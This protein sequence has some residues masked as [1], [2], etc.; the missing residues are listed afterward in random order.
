MKSIYV[1]ELKATLSKAEIYKVLVMDIIAGAK[2]VDWRDFFPYLRWIPNKQ[3]KKKIRAVSLRRNIVTKAM[4]RE[5]KQPIASGE[6]LA[7]S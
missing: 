2:D 7:F 6:V 4:I 3:W 5:Q 1:D